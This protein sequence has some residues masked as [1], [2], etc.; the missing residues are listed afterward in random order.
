MHLGELERLDQDGLGLVL[1]A[2]D[3]DD[4]V[5][6]Q[7]RN[8]K[9]A[10]NFQ[11]VI[12]LGQPVLGT[13][14]QHFAAVIEPFAQHLGKTQH[15]GHLAFDQH[16][17]VQRNAALKLGQ[18]EQRLHQQ[19]GIDGAGARLDDDANVFG[20]L[21]AEVLDQRQL[22][23]VEQL[24]QPLDQPRL[25]NQPR[26]LGDDDLIGAAAGLFLGPARADAERAAAGDVGFFNGLARI[27][28]HATG[29]EIR[30]W[31][32]VL[33]QR[34]RARIGIVDQEQRRVAKLM[35][36]VWRDRGCHADGDALRAVG[37]QVRECARQHNRLAFAAVVGRAEI[38]RVLVDAVDQQPRHLGEPRLRVT[39]GGRVIAV[40]VAEIAL[41]VDQ[42]IAL[43]EILREAHQRVIDRLV[44]VR[45]KFADDVAD[46]AGALL[47]GGAGIEAQL[48]HRKQ[49]PAM[50]RLETVA[51]VRQ[52]AMH[53][54]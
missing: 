12:N 15:L 51:R 50:H 35:R 34:A 36:V 29:R 21:V 18:L 14:H 22:L 1:V 19:L 49:H 42:R 20:G 25:L 46:D 28:D 16:V 43:R 3:L 40:D 7:I 53:D 26:N 41:P 13:P 39:H 38:D 17:H 8:E 52:R 33:H 6:I 11:P 5:E 44:A 27:D 32:V 2:N 30:A 24:R 54:G 45:M 37:E 9:T 47:E 10:E 48:P 31:H 4:L 23:V